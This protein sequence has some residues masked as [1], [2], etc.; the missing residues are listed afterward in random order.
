MFSLDLFTAV[1]HTHADVLDFGDEAVIG[2]NVKCTHDFGQL[3]F[4]TAPIVRTSRFLEYP[5]IGQR[6]FRNPY[7]SNKEVCNGFSGG[8]PYPSDRGFIGTRNLGQ[9]V[10]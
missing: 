4:S 9:S 2:I 3:E 6:F 10:S 7:I 1:T 5:V 8:T